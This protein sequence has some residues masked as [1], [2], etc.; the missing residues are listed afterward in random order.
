MKLSVVQ[1][2]E[3]TF[4]RT[5]KAKKEIQKSKDK[6]QKVDKNKILLDDFD[7]TAISR[8]ILSFYTRPKPELSTLD[9]IHQEVLGIPGIKKMSR[10]SIHRVKKNFGFVCKKR[11]KKMQVYQILDVAVQHHKYLQRIRQQK[12]QDTLSITRIKVGVILTTQEN[13]CGKKKTKK[14]H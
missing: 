10:A 4:Y 14:N 7:K 6:E 9:N 3:R 13:M 8:I 11:N 2:S 1:N 12:T 5:S